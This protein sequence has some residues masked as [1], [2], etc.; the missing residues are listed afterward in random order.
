VAQIWIPKNLSE[1]ER[2]LWQQ[3]ARLQEG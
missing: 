1:P 3:L 2:D